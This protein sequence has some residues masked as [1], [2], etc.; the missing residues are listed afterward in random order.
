M[1]F[2]TLLVVLWKPNIFHNFYH[3]AGRR[4]IACLPWRIADTDQNSGKLEAGQL[5]GVL[6]KFPK[7]HEDNDL[8]SC[9]ARFK[10]MDMANKLPGLIPIRV[11]VDWR[12]ARSCR[13]SS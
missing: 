3:Y 5:R 6:M 7:L 13:E 10:G 11:A 1:R 2:V 9:H 4:A 12:I 8:V